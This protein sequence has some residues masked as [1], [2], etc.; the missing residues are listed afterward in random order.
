M[1]ETVSFRTRV[2]ALLE[3][4]VDRIFM[5][6]CSDP[7]SIS[8]LELRSR[9]VELERFLAAIKTKTKRRLIVGIAMESNENWLIANFGVLFSDNVVLPVPLEFSNGQL[10]ALLTK[11]DICLVANMEQ[12]E[13]LSL[14]L[15]GK[16]LVVLPELDWLT[17]YVEN[18]RNYLLAENIVKIIHTS[19]TT[20]N[21]KGVLVTDQGLSTITTAVENELRPL[22]ALRYF[23]MVPFSLLIE[24]VLGIYL[25]LFTGGALILKP[26]ELPDFSVQSGLASR[27][28]QHVKASGANCV[29]LPPKLLEETEKIIATDKSQIYSLFGNTMPHIV[30][31][32]A[33]VAPDLLR[34][35]QR[36]GVPV[37][38][39]YG[40]SE[41]SSVVSMNTAARHK[42]GSVGKPLP[43]IE[44]AFDEGELLIKSPSLCAGYLGEDSSACKINENGFLYTGDMGHLD[45]EGYLYIN[46][47]KKN[48]IILSNARNV[49]PEWVE[50][51]YKRD[52]CFDDI[53]VFGDGQETLKAA[54]FS[55]NE[56]LTRVEVER[57]IKSKDDDLPGFSRVSSFE[58]LIGQ[59]WRDRF[60]TVTGRPKREA[61]ENYVKERDVTFS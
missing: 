10:Q 55:R 53:V 20:S 35:L 42:L 17:P 59:Y 61:I 58:L 49:C 4:A 30:T 27:Y 31:G 38:E 45:D 37:Y 6:R 15:P 39:G 56:A 25:P 32:G 19:G 60:F 29:Y 51:T 8:L 22:G 16:P 23:S 21:P 52:A 14:I 57:S 13:R 26:K 33:K 2:K 5:E 48:I 46:G 11:A 34:R 7:A 1:V 44:V 24:Q 36:L 41:N 9:A 43:H 40:L 47:R 18:E 3:N 54:I 50:Q 12:A 28:L